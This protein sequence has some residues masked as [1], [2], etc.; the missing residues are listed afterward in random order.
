MK[1]ALNLRVSI[2]FHKTNGHVNSG[3]VFEIINFYPIVYI[4]EYINPRRKFEMP[5]L[6]KFHKDRVKF[7]YT[8]LYFE[9]LIEKIANFSTLD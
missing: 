2:I 1:T 4:H 9:N 8:F 7:G 3:L 5:N 6:Y